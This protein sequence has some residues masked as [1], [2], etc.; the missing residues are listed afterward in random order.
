[1]TQSGGTNDIGV[2]FKQSIV[3]TSVMPVANPEQQVQVFPN[4]NDGKF[5][6]IL[7]G[8]SGETMSVEIQNLLGETI[9]SQ[10][11][12]SSFSSHGTLT[13]ATRET[14]DLSFAASGIYWVKVFRGN[15]V[16]TRK[17]LIY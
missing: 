2:I 16:S 13:E 11:I 12:I 9:Y 14:V 1:M 4:P 5:E 15:E 8:K 6:I 3:V 10:R 17:V 7:D